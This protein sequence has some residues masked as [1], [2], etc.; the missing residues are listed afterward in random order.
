MVFVTPRLQSVVFVT[1]RLQSVVFVTPR[2][3][4]VVLVLLGQCGT[5]NSYAS[6]VLILLGHRV[7]YL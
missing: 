6:V 4:S 2:S 1:P 7:W 3:Q 5:C